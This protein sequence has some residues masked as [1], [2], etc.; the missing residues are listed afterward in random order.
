MEIFDK[1]KKKM[2][3]SFFFPASFHNIAQ[4]SDRILYFLIR[5]QSPSIGSN[6]ES[7]L[8]TYL[9]HTIPYILFKEKFI[10]C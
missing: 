3:L 1:K 10:I 4:S 9:R 8:E 7:Y 6:N 2:I 5:H